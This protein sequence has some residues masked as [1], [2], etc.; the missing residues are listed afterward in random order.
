MI[1]NLFFSTILTV[2]MIG[3]DFIFKLKY[4]NYIQWHK[5]LLKDIG[6]IFLVNLLISFIPSFQ[7]KFIIYTVIFLLIFIQHFHY[8]FFR[9]YIMPYEIILL[10]EEGE[11]IFLT[12]KNTLKYM[13]FPV[14]IFVLALF[15]TY[16][17]L[18]FF[19]CKL[20]YFQY[21][22]VS[23]FVLL[24]IG[25]L[26]IGKDKREKFLPQRYFSSI[27]NI[28]YSFAYFLFREIPKL[29][30]KTNKKFIP[31]EVK[32][33]NNALPNT[34]IVIMGESLSSKRMSLFG[35]KEKTTPYLEKRKGLIYKKIFS[36]AT[37]TKT[38]V[39]EF[40][41]I[42]R[43]P[44]NIEH[45]IHQNCNLFKLAKSQGYKTHYITTQKINI[46]GNYIGDCDVVMSDKDFNKSKLY[47]EALV[48]YL[49]K[50]DFNEKNFIVLHQRN[51][52]SPYEDNV[53]EKFYK[54]NFKHKDFH[55]YMLNS[56][57]NSVLYT[58]Y[59][60]DK[61]FDIVD[62]LQKEAVVFITS[63]HGEMLGFE[64]EKGQYGHTVL[65]FEVLK[66]PLI[67][68]KNRH[69]KMDFN[70]ENIISHY[71]FAKLIANTIGFDIVN[72]NED[73][74]FYA[75]GTD[76]RGNHGYLKYT[77]KDYYEKYSNINN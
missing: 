68:Y 28:I 29:F 3:A 55:K 48:E 34:V 26:L 52:H 24:V 56:Y 62:G 57:L 9:S 5:K 75:N 58:D 67:I 19:A 18:K 15:L 36:S 64:D 31:Y 77:F 65:D 50:V 11:E 71:Q 4:K 42:R 44:E 45:L 41:N 47:D 21:A 1:Y 22:G 25:L 20:I 35:Y 37:V 30:V 74:V 51:S 23:F 73:G 10:F 46:L 8:T 40:F 53:P 38:S 63:D 59:L 13:L 54:Y 27:K 69:C 72:K 6:G 2:L 16:M 43:E 33:L 7:T 39:V 76:I 60:Y 17:T 70:I 49:K 12:L 66:V 61:I 14:I 32:K